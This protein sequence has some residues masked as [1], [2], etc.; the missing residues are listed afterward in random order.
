MSEIIHA[1]FVD[2][3][4]EP[5]AY[6]VSEGFIHWPKVNRHMGAFLMGGASINLVDRWGGW[7]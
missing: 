7:G 3:I 4:N 2:G 1:H 6:I 5:K